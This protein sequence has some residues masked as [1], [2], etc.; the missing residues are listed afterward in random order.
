MEAASTRNAAKGECRTSCL[1]TPRRAL[2]GA[3]QQSML[4]RRTPSDGMPFI[5]P[6]TLAPLQEAET[7]GTFAALDEREK[8]CVKMLPS[9]RAEEG[10]HFLSQR[11]VDVQPFTSNPWQLPL[12][13][14]TRICIKVVHATGAFSR[15]PDFYAH[16]GG[17]FHMPRNA[18]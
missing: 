5:L 4:L 6:R 16:V 8:S 10:T 12:T 7:R 17:Y 9:Y 14:H 3:L 2:L 13:T 1:A 15:H 11:G 18:T